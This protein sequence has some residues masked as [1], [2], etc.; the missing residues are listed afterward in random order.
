MVNA[1]DK[2]DYFVYNEHNG[3]L[4]FDADGK[5]RPRRDRAG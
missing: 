3:V 5:R 1:K 4:S 2:D